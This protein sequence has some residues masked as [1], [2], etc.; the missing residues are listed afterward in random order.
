[1]VMATSDPYTEFEHEVD[2]LMRVLEE[3]LPIVFPNTTCD[4]LV[5]VSPQLS[6]IMSCWLMKHIFC[7]R[8]SAIKGRR[9][10]ASLC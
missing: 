6:R 3:D 7:S 2:S 9:R 5:E 1:M 8:C 10:F 4:D